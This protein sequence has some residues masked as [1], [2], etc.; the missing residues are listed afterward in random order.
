M[1]EARKG[2][3]GQVVPEY[4]AATARIVHGGKVEISDITL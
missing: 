1:S 3:Q 2:G 4:C